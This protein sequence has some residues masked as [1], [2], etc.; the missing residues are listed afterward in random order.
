MAAEIDN[1]NYVMIIGQMCC[2]VISAGKSAVR[3]EVVPIDSAF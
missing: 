3:K 1:G 2:V